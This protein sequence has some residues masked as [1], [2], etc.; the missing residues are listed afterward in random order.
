[1]TFSG[2]VEEFDLNTLHLLRAW[3]EPGAA[4][5]TVSPDGSELYIAANNAGLRIVDLVSGADEPLVPLPGLYDVK[6]LPGS[7]VIVADGV[8]GGVFVLDRASRVL[9]AR[10]PVGGAPR[11]MAVDPTGH[12]II[13]ANE[14]G[15]VDFIQ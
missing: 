6:V 3:S 2:G 14:S 9:I 1:M 13:E 12:L 5:T 8:R 7:D 15:W 4:G 10:L 11:G